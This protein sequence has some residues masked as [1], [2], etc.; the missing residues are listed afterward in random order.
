MNISGVINFNGADRVTVDGS[1]GGTSHNLT[2]SNTSTT[3]TVFTFI[4]DATYNTIKYCNITGENTAA[5]GGI[6]S[7]ST[8]LGT[9]GND[10]NT[11]SNCNIYNATGGNSYVGIYATGTVGKENDNITIQNN[12]IY[13]LNI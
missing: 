12:N 7:F 5:T 11:I 13:D 1:S 6:I 2:F 4:N 8:T 9:T 3:G 10:Y